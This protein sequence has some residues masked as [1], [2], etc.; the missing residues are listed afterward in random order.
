MHRFFVISTLLILCGLGGFLCYAFIDFSPSEWQA[1]SDETSLLETGVVFVFLIAALFLAIRFIG[2]K[3]KMDFIFMMLMMMA[4]AREMSWHKEW[5]SDSILKSRF[6]LSPETPILEKIIGASVL[7]FLIYATFQLIKRVP[8]F[9]TDL[10]RFHAESIGIAMAIGLLVIAKAIDSKDRLPYVGDA[11]SG[12]DG[13]YLRLIEE[14]F[15]MASA[16]FFVVVAV[17]MVKRRI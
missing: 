8:I 6:Y 15:E 17:M 4:A 16:L 5:T 9:I 3:G 13:M 12:Y 14:S 10:W 2:T 1:L 11:L 7:L